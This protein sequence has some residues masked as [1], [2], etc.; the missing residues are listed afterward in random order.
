LI[1]FGGHEHES[2]PTGEA[3]E[4]PRRANVLTEVLLW[5]SVS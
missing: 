3:P 5:F 2:E 1:N 4:L